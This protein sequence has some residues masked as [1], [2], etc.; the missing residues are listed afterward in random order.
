MVCERIID[1]HNPES[2]IF[3]GVAGALNKELDIGDVVISRDCIH[4]DVD[5]Q[6]LGFS[7]GTIPYTD[8]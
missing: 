3:S 6:A 5:V 1:A 8:L 4:H 2:I 7:R